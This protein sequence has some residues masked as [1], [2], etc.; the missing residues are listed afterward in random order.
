[1]R[2]EPHIRKANYSPS[3]SR[4]RQAVR[5]GRHGRAGR[6]LG[7]VF[8]GTWSLKDL[9]AH[10]VGWDYANLEAAQAILAGRRPA[11]WAQRDRDWQTFNARL[12]AEYR[13]EDPAELL[14]LL[15]DSHRQLLAFVETFPA[16]EFFQ[17]H[18]R[19]RLSTILRAEARDEQKHAQQI[20]ELAGPACS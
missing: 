14:A 15:H 10:L 11:F 7:R 18:G 4:A 6:P 5:E 9:L 20:R 19:D 13:R 8:L 2:A 12:V 16:E 1:M 3:W 17:L